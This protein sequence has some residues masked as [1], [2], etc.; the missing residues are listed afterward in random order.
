MRM[1][2]AGAMLMMAAGCVPAPPAEAEEIGDHGGGQCD[3]A[4][5]QRLVGRKATAELGA[6][7]LRLTG[8]RVLRRIPHGGVVTMDYSEGRLNL[9]LDPAG[10]VAK[11]Y[12][13]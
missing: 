13:G 6:E 8:A 2:A 11:I 1:A 5:A 12:C 4:K 9:Q 3:A 7:A 10:K